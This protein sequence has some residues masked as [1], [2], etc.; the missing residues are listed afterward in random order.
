MVPLHHQ[1]ALINILI[2][3][4]LVSELWKQPNLA[5]KLAK[6]FKIGKNLK[7]R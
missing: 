5:R 4:V 6:V 1:I 2:V 7:I 3:Q